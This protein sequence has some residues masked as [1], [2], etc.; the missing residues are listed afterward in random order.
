MFRQLVNLG[1][2]NVDPEPLDARIE[3]RLKDFWEQT[4]CPRCDR[5]SIRTWPSSDR[6]IC[7]NCGFKPRYIYGTPFHEKHLSCGEALLAFLLYA[8]TLLNITQI[9][10]LL[11][12]AYRTVYLVS[13]H[14]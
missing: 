1:V 3:R 7:R 2:I 12:R 10:D 13:Q 4:A 9:G 11:D 8:D 5:P 14:E 6:I